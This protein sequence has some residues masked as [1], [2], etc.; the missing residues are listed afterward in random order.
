MAKYILGLEVG[1]AN[2]KLLE[3][4]RQGKQ[5]VI[6]KS[7]ILPSTKGAVRDGRIMKIEE[8]YKKISETIKKEKYKSKEILAVIT[9]SEII[10]RDIKI[11]V[12]P[13][14]DM[15][16][17]LALQHQEHLLV[18]IEAYQVTYKVGKK[19]IHEGEKQEVLI[20]AAPNKIIFPLIDLAKR[21]KM[22]MRSINIAPD[23]IANLFLQTNFIIGVEEEMMIVDIG[24][25]S[26]TI[27]IV[28]D[29]IGVLS[30]DIAFGMNTI[31][32]LI[33]D[34]IAT[35]DAKEIEA[36]KIK[37]LEIYDYEIGEVGSGQGINNAVKSIIGHKLVL[38]TQR[39]LQFHY[40]RK[41]KNVLKKV[42]IVGGGAYLK[43]IDKYMT[44]SLGV[45]CVAGIE[46][47]NAWLRY[48]DGF[49][50][51]SAYYANILGLVSE[52]WGY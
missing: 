17:I 36:F 51:K 48:G 30:R 28:S 37:N 4:R 38:E 42:Y 1:N 35:E 34:E 13:E 26:T 5:L 12:M 8:I 52:F 15:H 47:D 19:I 41:N 31:N 43:N 33:I 25:N 39:F 18:N 2:I 23:A 27:T 11:D 6:E 10:T 44:R 45:T 20:V 29:G 16:A 9:S 24:G 40:S 49:E 22:R 7:Q 46:L 21:L 14:K 3:C 50:K 32:P